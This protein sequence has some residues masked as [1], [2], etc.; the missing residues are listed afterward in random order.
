M[1]ACPHT[2]VLLRRVEAP[3]GPAR[4]QVTLDVMAGFGRRAMHDL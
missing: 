3:D 2:A 1:P 4:L